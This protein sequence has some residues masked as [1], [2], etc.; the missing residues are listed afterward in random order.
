MMKYLFM[1]FFV[2]VGIPISAQPATEVITLTGT[3]YEN[4]TIHTKGSVYKITSLPFKDRKS[5]V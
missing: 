5:V 2:L 1:L 3:L 4:A